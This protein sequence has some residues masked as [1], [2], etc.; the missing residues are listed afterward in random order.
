MNDGMWP[1]LNRA[2]KGHVLLYRVTRGV[3]GHRFPGAPPMLLLENV[4]AKT[5]E[6]RTTPLAYVPDGENVVVVA[7]KG[8]N[9]R[10]P[11][12]FHNLMA[13]PNTTVQIG[14][15]HRPVH[16]RVAT[17]EERKTLWPKAV[18]FYKPYGEYQKKTSREIPLVILEPRL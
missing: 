18:S 15:E 16:A 1:W 8:G 9:P 12:W 2:F 4:G 11:A 13:H 5:G 3:I 17:A 10:N 6:K 14:S 7:S